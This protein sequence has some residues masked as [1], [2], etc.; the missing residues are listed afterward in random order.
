MGD[1]KFRIDYSGRFIKYMSIAI[2]NLTF[3]W[4]NTNNSLVIVCALFYGWMVVGIRL[5]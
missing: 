1:T 4:V 5:P 2:I 3:L